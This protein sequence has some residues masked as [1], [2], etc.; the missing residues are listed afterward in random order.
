MQDERVKVSAALVQHPP[1]VPSFAYRF[2]GPD[3]PADLPAL[4][5]GRR[6]LIV[7][8]FFYEPGVAGWPETGGHGASRAPRRPDLPR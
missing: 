5:A 7:Y 3:G 6:Q 1:V 8:R 4:F 2:D